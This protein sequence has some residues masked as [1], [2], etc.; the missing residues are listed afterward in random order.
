MGNTLQSLLCDSLV[1]ISWKYSDKKFSVPNS[2]T[3]EKYLHSFQ[4]SGVAIQHKYNGKVSFV[5]V[6]LHATCDHG[7]S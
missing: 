3:S 6:D 1:S 5:L 2:Y 7:I 4:V